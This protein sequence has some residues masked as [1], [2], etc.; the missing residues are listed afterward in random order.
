[1]GARK[2]SSPTIRGQSKEAMNRS[3]IALLGLGGGP[4]GERCLALD[5]SGAKTSV[6]MRLLVECMVLHL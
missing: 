5:S 2:L 6:A 1:V 4:M 3:L